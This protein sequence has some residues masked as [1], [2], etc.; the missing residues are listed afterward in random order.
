MIRRFVV[1]IGLVERSAVEAGKLLAL[2]VRGLRQALARGVILW[3]NVQLLDER[4]CLVV[5]G[6]VVA[7]HPLR[8]RAHL[9]VLALVERLLGRLDVKL[10]RRIGDMRDLWIGGLRG[11]GG[12]RA[13]PTLPRET[14]RWRLSCT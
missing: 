5:H 7:Y 3:R 13:A 8:K 12:D 6:C 1:D 2:G 14:R 4:E 11:G 9:L 10:S